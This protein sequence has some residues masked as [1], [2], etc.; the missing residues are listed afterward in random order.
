MEYVIQLQ[1]DEEAGVWIAINDY[2]PLTLESESIDEL[3]RKVRL[4][5]PELVEMNHMT[6][7]R[8]LHFFA[9]NREEIP[10]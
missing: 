8:Y 9:E 7:P 6:M 3:M 5:V 4:A 10:A 2:L 1:W